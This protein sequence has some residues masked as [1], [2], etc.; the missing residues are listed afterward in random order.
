MP[1]PFKVSIQYGHDDLIGSLQALAVGATVVDVTVSARV[2]L[3]ADG[4]D[5][6]FTLD[7]SDP[8]AG[9]TGFILADGGPP[10]LL[11]FLDVGE[12]KVVAVSGSPK[13]QIQLLG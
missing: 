8:V 4:A 11:E 5:I 6:R 1:I 13:L 7:G 9:T 10:F 12:L 2:M 3:Q